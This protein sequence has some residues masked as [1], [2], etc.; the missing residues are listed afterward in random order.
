MSLVLGSSF[1]FVCQLNREVG[2]KVSANLAVN[3]IGSRDRKVLICRDIQKQLML[4]SES[5][6][7]PR[8][9]FHG[10]AWFRF[11]AAAFGAKK[12]FEQSA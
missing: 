5:G 3:Q 12:I 10:S 7:S 2:D 4:D 6:S 8:Q 1:I 9:I 11:S